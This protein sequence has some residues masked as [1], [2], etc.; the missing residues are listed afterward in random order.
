MNSM[1]LITFFSLL[2]VYVHSQF[3]P[4]WVTN[5]LVQA[6]SFKII[7][8]DTTGTKVGGSA[9]RTGILTFSTAFAGIPHLGY[10]ISGM[11]ST[12]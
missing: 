12:S 8:G 9:T 2:V 6:R 5:A 4:T 11:K 1:Y 7:D 3:T 10:G